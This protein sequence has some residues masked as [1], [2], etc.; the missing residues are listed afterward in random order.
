ML[1]FLQQHWFLIGLVAVIFLAHAVPWLGATGGPLMPEYS[2]K[3]GAV[4]MIF[5]NS[6]LTLRT[7][8][9]AAAALQYRV[10]AMI[11]GFT[12]ILVPLCVAIFVHAAP[13]IL[14]DALTN[15][16]VLAHF[17]V[18]SCMPPPVSSAVIL[19]KAANGNEAAAIF[20]SALGSFLGIFATPALLMLTIGASADM[21]VGK[22]FW[23]LSLTVVLPLILGQVVRF[24]AW[25]RIRPWNIPFG[26]I[27]SATL[28]LIIFSTFCNTFSSHVE[29]EVRSLL[30]VVGL[31]II[32]LMAEMIVLF[33]ATNA[34]GF[35]PRDVVCILFCA[36]HK[37]LTLGIPI[38]N[39]VFAGSP[40]LSLVS[41][42]LLVYHPTQILLGG[43]LVPAVRSW[44]YARDRKKQLASEA[45]QLA[46]RA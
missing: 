35:F 6:G 41:L 43:I 42:P 45:H 20:N 7:E 22:I 46:P 17:T 8:D 25:H 28:L 38:L 27:S 19:T 15:G 2:I 10:H 3:Y 1:A 23:S 16:S 24:E 18:L 30:A 34:M 39:I 4:F 5:F 12:L 14:S 26:N 13:A 40:Q 29:V 36:T 11:Q 33:V 31:V 9:L 32:M 44:L 37:S 21:D